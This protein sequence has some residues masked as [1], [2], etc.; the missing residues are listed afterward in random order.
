MRGEFPIAGKS[1]CMKAIDRLTKKITSERLSSCEVE[2]IS[3][4]I[5]RLKRLLP[6]QWDYQPHD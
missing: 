6:V 5:R 3:D 4:E 2:S 1:P